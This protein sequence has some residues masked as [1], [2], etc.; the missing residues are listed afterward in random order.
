M[1]V[2]LLDESP[3]VVL[4][5]QINNYIYF[6]MF[7]KL[8]RNTSF[9]KLICSFL[10]VQKSCPTYKV[11]GVWAPLTTVYCNVSNY[12]WSEALPK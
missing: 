1:L 12:G 10:I 7:I 4:Q 11:Y 5:G 9:A 8:L 2:Y 3:Y 6:N